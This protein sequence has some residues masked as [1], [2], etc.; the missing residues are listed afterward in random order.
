MESVQMQVRSM[1]IDIEPTRSRSR[2]HTTHDCE[3]DRALS[4]V[5]TS[6]MSSRAAAPRCELCRSR[7][8]G[9]SS[10]ITEI[11]P[12]FILAPS[13]RT[14]LPSWSPL[15]SIVCGGEV[16]ALYRPLL[17]KLLYQWYHKFINLGSFSS[18]QLHTTCK[19]REQRSTTWAP[20]GVYQPTLC[21]VGSVHALLSE[22][23]CGV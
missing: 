21:V 20:K 4:I 5:S 15:G 12:P 11:R 13:R 8:R 9:N 16:L 17:Y 18:R 19:L 14:T 23:S 10:R 22:Y 3:T 1:T 7:H 2:W 6:S